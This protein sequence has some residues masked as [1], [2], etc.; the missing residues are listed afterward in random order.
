VRTWDTRFI[1]VEAWPELQ[2]HIMA[3]LE[4]RHVAW[5]FSPDGELHGP[6]VLDAP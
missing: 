4:T 6:L 5:R 3:P 1:E 2:R